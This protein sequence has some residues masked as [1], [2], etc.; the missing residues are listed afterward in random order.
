MAK[1]MD[2]ELMNRTMMNGEYFL[3]NSYYTDL[4][5][6]RTSCTNELW[7]YDPE[8]A[9]KLLSEAG[10][11][12]NAQG[13]L[14]KNG[15]E[16]VFTFLS[17]SQGDDKFLSLFN[18]ALRAQGVTMKIDRKDFA[19]WMRDMD[20]YN[21]DMTWAAWG[22]S[23]IRNPESMWKSSEGRNK[24][25]N[26]VTGFADAEVDAI[27]EREKTMMT[28]SERE[29]AYRRIDALVCAQVPYNMLWHTDE[30]RVLYWNRFGVPS[31]VFGRYGDEDG[32]LAYWWFDADK[33]RELD[34]AMSADADLS[35][36][37]L[38]AVPLRV[39]FK[40]GTER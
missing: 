1:L 2:R 30:H 29:D 36:A 23:L 22:A 5:R 38:P 7:R 18:S 40:T 24:G 10:W 13:L 21:F 25:G 8:G 27:I 32:I 16:F 11:R 35:E 17:R 12:R 31:S 39:D 19:G 15:R 9:A 6:P 37:F 33:A 26:N 4:Y 14:E 20:Q 28:N 34:E 3:L